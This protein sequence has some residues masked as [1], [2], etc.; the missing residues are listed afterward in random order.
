MPILIS[1][2]TH[3]NRI[4]FAG[5]NPSPSSPR[6]SKR[7]TLPID[8]ALLAEDSW[9]KI[10][11]E[12][13]LSPTRANAVEQAIAE[14]KKPGMMSLGGRPFRQ[15]LAAAANKI[16]NNP[17]KKVHHEY[18]GQVMSAIAQR[19][20]DEA[21]E[22]ELMSGEAHQRKKPANE[23]SI[24]SGLR[25]GM[26]LHDSDSSAFSESEGD[27]QSDDEKIEES[28]KTP[29]ATAS[30]LSLVEQ[31]K[32]DKRPAKVKAKETY[33]STTSQ[34]NP[35]RSATG[36]TIRNWP[37]FPKKPQLKKQQFK[38]NNTATVSQESLIKQFQEDDQP[39]KIKEKATY[40]STTSQKSPPTSAKGSAIRAWPFFPKKEQS[41]LAEQATTSQESLITQY[42]ADEQ[43]YADKEH[44]T[45]TST[46]SLKTPPTSAKGNTIRRWPFFKKT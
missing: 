7:K 15:I 21:G 24:A 11:R 33:T 46:T 17:D 32:Q 35:P 43:P 18:V 25:K 3:S 20:K 10:L 41:K 39:Y 13:D 36:G 1:N 40:I 2:T 34:T 22:L 4:N 44:Y 26:Q 31:Y 5:G 29:S 30:Q 6:T 9:H 28:S 12:K 14:T 23:S 8:P 16:L 37:F 19:K 27:W 42:L 38:P 45:Y